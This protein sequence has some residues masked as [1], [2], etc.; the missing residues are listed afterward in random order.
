MNK[1]VINNVIEECNDIIRIAAVNCEL[2]SEVK[3]RLNKR[4]LNRNGKFRKPWFNKE[5][6]IQRKL[7]HKANNNNWRVRTV[8]S[9]TNLIRRSK[10][11]KKI[12]NTQF[13]LYNKKCINK[14][15]GLKQ[16]DPNFYWSLLNRTCSNENK[17]KFVNNVSFF[18]FGAF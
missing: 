7:Y 5:C 13:H 17:Q 18:F 10:E 9:N 14:L 2:L 15:R 11:Y 3:N 12:S 8:E 6:S 1:D 16:T 4:G